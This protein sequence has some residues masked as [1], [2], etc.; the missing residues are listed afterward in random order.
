MS[1]TPRTALLLGATGLVGGHLLRLLARDARWGG[2]VTVGRRAMPAVGERHTH[3]VVDFER[4]ADAAEAFS[5]DDVF[6]ALG[7]TIGQAGSKRQFERVDLDYPFLAAQLARHGGARQF[8]LVSAMSADPHSRLFY[9]R[10]KGRLEALVREVGFDGV[11]IFRP[12]LITGE[13][14]ERRLGE[15][16]AGVVLRALDPVL[17]GPLRKVRP[18]PASTIAHA[19]VEVGARQRPGTHVYLSDVRAALAAGGG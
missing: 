7:T 2:V 1:E 16:V 19:M 18:N 10:T 15:R 4:L 11:G 14:R 17:V 9:S 8:L 6:C 5:A 12:S 13:R 3:H